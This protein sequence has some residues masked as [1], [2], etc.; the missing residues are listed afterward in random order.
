MV[1]CSGKAVY[2]TATL[3]YLLL[4]ALIA[5]A[6]TLEGADDGLRYFFHPDWSLLLKAEVR[7]NPLDSS[8]HSVFHSMYGLVEMMESLVE[9]CLIMLI[10]QVW[11]NALAQTF[12]S[13]GIAYGS[14]VAFASYN[15][16]QSPFLRDA[17]CLSAL[18][19]SK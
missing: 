11:V 13:M 8:V 1:N 4:L 15:Q 3:P 5:R 9:S 19:S 18:N 6:L 10:L 14:L 7:I 2:V 16:F 12:M 17:F